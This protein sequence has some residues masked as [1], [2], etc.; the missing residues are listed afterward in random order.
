MYFVQAFHS[1]KLTIDSNPLFNTWYRYD[2]KLLR[3]SLVDNIKFPIPKNNSKINNVPRLLLISVDVKEGATVTFDSYTKEDGHRKS[4]YGDY[5]ES[6]DNDD[7]Q[8][9][10]GYKNLIEYDQGIMVEH[11]MASASVPE[12][13][14]YA[15]VPK[16]YDYGKNEE[17]KLKEIEVERSTYLRKNHNNNDNSN[18]NNSNPYSIFWDGGIMSNTPLRELIQAHQD[19][20]T[21]VEKKDTVPSLEVYIVDLHPSKDNIYFDHDGVK[22][23]I[24]DIT[25]SD[26]TYYDEKVAN[27]VS[28]YINLT[29]QM[30]DL[31]T[32]AISKV[33]NESQKNVLNAE[34]EDIKRTQAISKHRTE[35]DRYY[36]DLLKGSRFN[37]QINRIER[38]NDVNSISNKTLDFSFGTIN[39]LIEDGQNDTLLLL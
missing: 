3:K 20:W 24:N 12:H 39:Q 28:D 35:Q 11:V 27:L 38:Q 25:Y 22:N 29:M 26:R 34:F 1:P 21:K 36:R 10:S 14:D 23:R 13:F 18:N 37:I 7:N 30:A 16:K 33:N 2:N 4:E 19:Y 17:E 15:L 5:R 31:L 8:K 6:N 32:E 9:D